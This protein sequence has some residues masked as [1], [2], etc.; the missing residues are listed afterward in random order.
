MPGENSRQK[1]SIWID[2][3]KSIIMKNM[4]GSST[5][6]I[7][8]IQFLALHEMHNGNYTSAWNLVGE[9][10]AYQGQKQKAKSDCRRDCYPHDTRF[11]AIRDGRIDL[12]LA[13]RMPPTADVGCFCI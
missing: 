11:A 8:A 9:S 13:T 7:S 3:A 5:L 6:T 1:G 2:E 10:R 12:V 4:G